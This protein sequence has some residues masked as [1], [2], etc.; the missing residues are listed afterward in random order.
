M[1][2][3]KTFKCH[4]GR[5]KQSAVISLTEYWLCSDAAIP[6]LLIRIVL[7]Q[8]TA[9]L[10][11]ACSRPSCLSLE[12]LPGRN[13][14]VC[15]YFLSAALTWMSKVERS[16][17]LHLHFPTLVQTENNLPYPC[18]TGRPVW[19]LRL[20]ISSRKGNHPA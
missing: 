4:F 2:M 17:P 1:A 7:H 13:M 14:S 12:N 20:V 15:I 16:K 3:A 11:P 8:A 19:L 9:H 6:L 5:L 18:Y 10:T